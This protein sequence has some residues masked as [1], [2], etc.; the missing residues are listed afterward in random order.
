METY[1]KERLAVLPDQSG[2]YLMKDQ[3]GVAIYVGKAHSL[4]DRVRSYFHKGASLSLRI[5]SMIKH[6]ADIEWMVTGSD[7]EALILENNLIKK[8]KPRYNVILRDDKNYPFLR[9]SVEDKFP[10]ITVVRRIRQDGALYF[11][12]YVPVNAM[13]ETLKVIKKVFPLATCKIDLSKRY[14]K[15]CVE[16]EIGRCAG[17]CVGVIS[18]EGY[19]KVVI[20]LRLFL[21][22]KDG[23][24]LRSMKVQ[25]NKEADKLNFEEA[26]RIRDRIFRIEKVLERQRIVS[27]EAK[28]IDV[29]GLAREGSTVDLQVLFFRGGML[30]GRKDIFYEKAR[31]VTD[32]EI[33]SSFIEQFYSRAVLIPSEIVLPVNVLEIELVKRW[34]SERRNGKVLLTA[35]RRGKKLGMLRLAI[36]NAQEAIKGYERKV[37]EMEKGGEELQQILDLSIIPERIEAFDI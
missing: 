35:P 25:M 3:K 17:P 7:L 18:E 12:P 36:E 16:Y 6:V 10:R 20:D 9:L 22:G 29:V 11:G 4:R 30:V 34:L 37:K 23:E 32:E 5:K 27:A 26:A 21:E 19:K 8:H 13:R 1:I 33:V 2:V 31:D 28:D 15:A 14:D 24:L